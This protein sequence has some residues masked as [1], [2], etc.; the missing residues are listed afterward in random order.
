MVLFF[1]MPESCRLLQLKRLHKK[2][3]KGA[4]KGRET[5]GH[6]VFVSEDEGKMDSRLLIDQCEVNPFLLY[7]CLRE[8]W[9]GAAH[10]IRV[11]VG[12]C[13]RACVRKCM[14]DSC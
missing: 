2:G 12:C 11:L 8:I 14:L 10:S 5:N 13:L 4:L 3:G 9:H 6:E 7:S 1:Y